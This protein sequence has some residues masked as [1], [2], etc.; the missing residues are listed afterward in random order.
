MGANLPNITTSWDHKNN[1][2][3]NFV[4]FTKK[5][6]KKGSAIAKILWDEVTGP[7]CGPKEGP[8]PYTLPTKVFDLPTVTILTPPPTSLGMISAK[9]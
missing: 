4:P 2:K 7:R 6:G 9:K 3:P 5:I 8:P 1:Q